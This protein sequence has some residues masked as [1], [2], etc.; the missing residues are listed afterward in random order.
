MTHW[1]R[2]WLGIGGLGCMVLSAVAG[3]ESPPL[4]LPPVGLPPIKSPVDWFRDLLAM[5]PSARKAALADRSP[6]S[7]RLLLAKVRE[8]ESLK[9]DVRELRLRATELRFYLLPL[10]MAPATNRPPQLLMVPPEFRKLIEPRLQEWDKLPVDVQTNLLANEATLSY[11]TELSA[12][13]ENRKMENLSPARRQKLQAGIAQ[14]QALPVAQRQKIAMHFNQFFDL[15]AD[16]KRKALN[17]LSEGERR[18]IEKTLATFGKL[19]PSQR[20]QCV[21]SF[22]KFANLSLEERRQFLKNAERWKLMS[23]EERDSWRQLVNNLSSQPP[24]PPELSRPLPPP[25]PRPAAP[26]SPRAGLPI[27]TNSN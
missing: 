8:Y 26:R 3:Q 19:T 17:T 18:Q 23:P 12:E 5:D 1:V 4:A 16:E 25:L 27:A 6:E 7:R 13:G 14:W 2:R 21:R 22:E 10:L 24:L 9:P 15:T 20:A 11:F